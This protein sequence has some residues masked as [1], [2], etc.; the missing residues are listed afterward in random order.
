M[1]DTRTNRDLASLARDVKVLKI[2]ALIVTVSLGAVALMGARSAQ[3]SR[4]L[5]VERINVVDSHGVTRL[6]IANPEH[7][8]L[9]RID[10]K[11]YP[12]AVAPAGMVFYD[13]NGSEIGG[14]ALSGNA[15]RKLSALAF[16]YP[17]YDALG[18]LTQ[19]GANDQS[20]TAGLVINSRAPREMS[21]PQAGKV[22]QRRVAVLNEN[23]NAEVLLADGQGHD[24]IKMIVDDHGDPSI[25]ILDAQGKVVF[26]APAQQ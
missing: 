16:D 17:N 12:R 5:T 9:P 26:R 22:V 8:P 2:Y 25:Q 4:E 11:E 18:L 23:E 10:G 24:R 13:S 19:V 20:A 15:D 21:L 14:L 1:S 7:F 6:V 3:D